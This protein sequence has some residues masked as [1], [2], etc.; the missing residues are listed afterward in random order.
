MKRKEWIL[1]FIILIFSLTFFIVIISF[2]QE[3]NYYSFFWVC[4]IAIP[5]LIFGLIKRNSNIILSQVIILAI[6]DLLWIIDFFYLIITGHVLIGVTTFR[7]TTPLIDQIRSL[8]HLYIVP[9]SILALSQIKLKKDYK[10]LLI[11]L[12][13]IILIFLLTLLIVPSNPLNINCIY[14]NCSNLPLNFLP[15][16]LLWLILLFILITVSYFIITS[17]PFVKKKKYSSSLNK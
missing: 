10:I 14:K 8:Q 11:G 1:D 15:Y 16:M 2:L 6:P 5:I 17:L 7:I 12:A 9:L 3:K 13:E 4:Y